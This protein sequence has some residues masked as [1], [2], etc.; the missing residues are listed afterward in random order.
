MEVTIVSGVSGSIPAHFLSLS[1]VVAED[2][3]DKG[4]EREEKR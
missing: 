3:K 4:R 2:I 1:Q